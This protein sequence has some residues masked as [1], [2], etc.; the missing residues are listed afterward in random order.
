[1]KK[2][3]PSAPSRKGK[4]A[5]A[6]GKRQRTVPKEV[7]IARLIAKHELTELEASWLLKA[8]KLAGVERTSNRFACYLA[9]FMV[10]IVLKTVE[11]EFK[12]R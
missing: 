6:S 8:W 10:G 5:R 11:S 2:L 12:S 4:T 1:M 9:G 7:I 3:S